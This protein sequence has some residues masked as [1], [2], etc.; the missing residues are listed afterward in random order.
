MFQTSLI[1]TLIFIFLILIMTILKKQ[2][3]SD[4]FFYYILKK[5]NL[6]IKNYKTHQDILKKE[7]QAQK[8]KKWFLEYE[9]FKFTQ[10][11][12]GFLKFLKL[13]FVVNFKKNHGFD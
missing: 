3:Y 9:K 4:W 10:K 8:Y 7:V 13:C 2:D 1:I 5:I 11:K 6:K 12:L